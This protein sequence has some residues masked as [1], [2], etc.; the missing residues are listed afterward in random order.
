[1]RKVRGWGV[2]GVL[3][4]VLAAGTAGAD[5]REAQPPLHTYAILLAEGATPEAAEGHLQRLS[6]R[7]EE[8]LP[9]GE[10]YPRVLSSAELPGLP[11]GRH[12]VVLGFCEERAEAQAVVKQEQ[13][14]AP[15]ARVAATTAEVAESC[16]GRMTPDSA[17]ELQARAWVGERGADARRGWF[18]YRHRN[19]PAQC[20]ASARWRVVVREG[21]RVL[22]QQVLGTTCRAPDEAEGEGESSQWRVEP[23]AVGDATVL[24]VVE[25]R[26]V[27]G[28]V[29]HTHAL[30]AW[31]CKRLVRKP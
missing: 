2:A 29:E 26:D 28:D 31:G 24:Y 27:A 12:Y 18:V 14:H 1:M 10:G 19:P 15:K 23:Y 4:G 13:P 6:Q 8:A 21:E 9:V 16:P 17:W 30:W 22:A 5:E 3:S 20:P 11:G 7:S 25:D